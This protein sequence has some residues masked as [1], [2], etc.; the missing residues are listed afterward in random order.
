MHLQT[1]ATGYA[2]RDRG[3]C[4]GSR[5]GGQTALANCFMPYRPND[6]NTK[7]TGQQ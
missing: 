1:A 4:W 7:E 5:P 6:L 3:K 2:K